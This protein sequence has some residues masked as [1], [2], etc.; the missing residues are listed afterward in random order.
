MEYPGR[1]VYPAG[2]QSL[3][4]SQSQFTQMAVYPQASMATP[5]QSQPQVVAPAAATRLQPTKYEPMDEDGS[6]SED[7]D[8]APIDRQKSFKNVARDINFLMEER[9]I[10]KCIVWSSC[11]AI[12]CFFAVIMPLV[13]VI[14]GAIITKPP[15]DWGWQEGVT[16]CDHYWCG[17]GD[18][19]PLT[20]ANMTRY[21]AWAGVLPAI[22]YKTNEMFEKYAAPCYKPQM[23]YD[24][25]TFNAANP[26]E[27]VTFKSRPAPQAKTVNL[28]AWCLRAAGS[29]V[30]AANAPRVVVQHGLGSSCNGRMPQ[31]TAYVLRTMGFDVLI[32]C[33]RGYGLSTDTDN[34]RTTWGWVYPYDTLGAW[35]YAVKDPD[36]CFGGETTPDKVG[37]LGFSLGAMTVASALG[38]EPKVAGAWIDSA[39]YT[40]K[41]VV[42]NAVAP[43]LN[44]LLPLVIAYAWQGAEFVSGVDLDRYI[45]ENT[46]PNRCAEAGKV[47]NAAVLGS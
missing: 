19:P 14:I 40:P 28:K 22:G 27:L 21:L 5:Q 23:I 32:P 1:P 33:M 38:L 36:N 39:P 6:A 9:R 15:V 20:P 35:D 41:G 10:Y 44:Y 11:C 24:M 4:G 31:F 13:G 17:P 43:Y 18:G 3:M 37:L 25:E 45:P 26:Y 12:F 34:P 29:S 2:S 46:I 8:E 42:S 7:G 47:R 16:A 30:R